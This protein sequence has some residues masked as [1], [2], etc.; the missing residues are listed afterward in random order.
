MH[1][2]LMNVTTQLLHDMPAVI[3]LT[4][5]LCR[6][7]TILIGNNNNNAI[8]PCH[9]LVS[10]LLILCCCCLSICLSIFFYIILFFTYHM[11]NSRLLQC[12]FSISKTNGGITSSLLTDKHWLRYVDCCD[13]LCVV[14]VVVVILLLHLN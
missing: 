1:P 4:Y 6:L 3:A 12:L 14:V 8:V 10:W 2:R 13:W 9:D 7:Q 11:T 5:P